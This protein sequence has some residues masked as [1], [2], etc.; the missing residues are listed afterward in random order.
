MSLDIFIS[1]AKPTHIWIRNRTHNI[2]D[3]QWEPFFL[4]PTAHFDGSVYMNTGTRIE[5]P[6]WTHDDIIVVKH[7]PI[8]TYSH[9]YYEYYI[10]WRGGTAYLNITKLLR[11]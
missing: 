6:T 4:T 10:P 3:A 8:Y 5:L 2:V 11:L 9:P 7:Q 1:D